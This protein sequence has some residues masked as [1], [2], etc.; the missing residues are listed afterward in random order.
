MPTCIESLESWRRHIEVVPTYIESVESWRRHIE[1]VPTY[2]DSVE[3]WRTFIQVMPTYI[4]LL[5][6]KDICLCLIPTNGV[7][8]TRSCQLKLQLKVELQQL[9]RYFFIAT[10]YVAIWWLEILLHII[11]VNIF[12]ARFLISDVGLW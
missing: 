6:Y 5:F 7:G 12:L 11:D 1:V 9:F 3:S 10:T 4:E 2:I 8:F